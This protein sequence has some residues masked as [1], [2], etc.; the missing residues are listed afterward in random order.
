MDEP[1]DCLCPKF[2]RAVDILGRRWTCLILSILLEGPRRFSEL[3]HGVPGIGGRMLSE[4]L[5]ALEA[6]GIVERRVQAGS[7]N[8]IE[9]NL[10]AKG[11][12]LKPAIREIEAW[13]DLWEPSAVGATLAIAVS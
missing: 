2:C 7:P 8:R 9:Y 13:A 11:H 12:G 6:Y 5:K 1:H 3:E 10:T 4:R